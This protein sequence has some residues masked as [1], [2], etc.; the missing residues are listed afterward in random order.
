MQVFG[1]P[2]RN[3]ASNQTVIGVL[4]VVL[5]LLSSIFTAR[6]PFLRHTPLLL[7]VLSVVFIAMVGGLSSAFTA[8]I[9]SVIASYWMLL[10]AHEAL[11][12]TSLRCSVLVIIGLFVSL[13]NNSR[14]RAVHA[15]EDRTEE[16]ILAQGVGR[17]ASW[18]YSLRGGFRW[19]R[20]GFE[21]FGISLDDLEVLPSP[22]TLIHPD[23]LPA[24]RSALE[25]MV[26]SSGPLLIEYR[27]IF[28]NGDLHWSEARGEFVPGK[29]ATWHGVTTDITDRKHAENALLR[30]EKLAAMGR[31][32][33]TVAHEI[34][35]PLE[36]VTNLLYL[37]KMDASQSD[38]AK[39]YL[40]TAEAELARL[41]D[42]TRLTLGF[43]RNTVGV[44]RLDPA[45]V[46][47]DVLSIFR[48]RLEQKNILVDRFY[49]PGN[50]VAIAPHE[51]RQI[52]TNLISNAADAVPA[53]SGRI[54]IQIE[55]RSQSLVISVD[56]N[57][58]GI[59]ASDIDRIF[60]PFFSTKHDVG[61]GIGLWVTRELVE[62]N[63]GS[64]SAYS[65][66]TAALTDGMHTS[67]Q[68]ELPLAVG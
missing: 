30:S 28:P 57:G 38:E 2:R 31:L 44:V 56:D 34:N 3:R 58:N 46:M 23:D 24:F 53:A 29:F 19:L 33:S 55:T 21:V 14:R 4:A 5:P 48:H 60:E 43:V 16:L 11:W 51:L 6:L 20:G 8:I 68:L 15:L 7:H 45:A 49:D 9:I 67:F 1:S 54:R 47:D 62:K 37:A 40:A 59:P 17:S 27:V 64:I 39:A 61:T 41:A 36:A 63:G 18:R 32:A 42:I 50:F 10:G 35:N 65:G 12:L 25:Q 66:G 52:L 26:A 22:T 13:M